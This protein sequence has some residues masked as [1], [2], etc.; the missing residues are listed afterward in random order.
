MVA[1][2]L[3]R[4]NPLHILNFGEND[5]SNVPTPIPAPP[6]WTFGQVVWGTLV[7]TAVG[8]SFWL[9]S[10][11]YQLLFILFIAI[12]IGTVLRPI[13]A[14]LNRRGVP[15]KAGVVLVYLF[16]L[17]GV[18]GFGVLLFPLI[19]EQSAKITAAIPGYYK[20]VREWRPTKSGPFMDSLSAILP[21]NLSFLDPMQTSAQDVL[22]SAEQVLAYVATAGSGFFTALVLLLLA[23]YWTLDGPRI[24]RSLLL[25]APLNQRESI[26]ELIATMEAKVGAYMAGQGVLILVVGG[27]SLFAYWLIGLPY[28][29]V[30]ALVAGLMEAV[31]L[32]GPLIGAIPALLVALTLG[33]DKLIWVI[34]AT[35]IIQQLENNF[36]VPRIMRRAVGVNPFV[37]L[38]ALF[39]FSSLLGVAGAL[40]AIPIAA[41][42][43]LLLDH[44]VFKPGTEP[45]MVNGRGYASRL[46]YETQ[47]LARD[48][49]QQT[50]SLPAGS[51]EQVQQIEQV[52]DQLEAIATDLDGLLASA[53]PP[54]EAA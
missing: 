25:L 10:Q 31:P 9:L 51:A 6:H 8:L 54:M 3:L 15:P 26:G 49:R 33:P 42:I 53:S 39:A 40:M 20:S 21:E 52:M 46:R 18:V 35:V 37:T 7:L 13:V 5:M 24:I 41:I 29:L 22:E 14:W 36:L 19:A 38:L 16:F 23:Y 28:L 48:L 17:A 32:I 34:V 2:P 11:F 27:M 43:Q 12:I 45:E 50:R 47:E 4:K 1:Q 30:L 44:F